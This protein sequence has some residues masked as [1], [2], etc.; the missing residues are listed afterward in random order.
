MNAHKNHLFV[1]FSDECA[2]VSLPVQEQSGSD[3]EPVSGCRASTSSQAGAPLPWPASCWHRGWGIHTHGH[4]N[5]GRSM[6]VS[7]DIV[8]PEGWHNKAHR[9]AQIFQIFQI[10]CQQMN[11]CFPI[12]NT[13]CFQ[14]LPLVS[15]QSESSL[16]TEAPPTPSM[17]KYRPAYNSP[18]R[19]HSALTHPNKV[20]IDLKLSRTQSIGYISITITLI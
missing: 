7:R 17:Y 8:A 15:C 4:V 6:H 18:G 5:T 2:C 10:S 14:M 12:T 19:N 13:L 1:C 9:A 20:R 11:V 3:G 16:L